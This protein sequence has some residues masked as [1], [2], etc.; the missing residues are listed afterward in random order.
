[1]P[2]RRVAA[3]GRAGECSLRPA[4]SHGKT[5]DLRRTR[6]G[7]R[8]VLRA[9]DRHAPAFRGELEERVCFAEQH[10]TGV[11]IDAKDTAPVLGRQR[12]DR[13]T[14]RKDAGVEHEHVNATEGRDGLRERGLE[15]CLVGEVANNSEVIA[16]LERAGDRRV[17]VEPHHGGSALQQRGY[18]GIRQSATPGGIDEES[19]AAIT[20]GLLLVLSLASCLVSFALE[21]AGLVQ[22]NR[23]KSFA[24]LGTIISALVGI[25]ASLTIL[26][27]LLVS[28]PESVAEH[29]A[30]NG[31][32]GQFP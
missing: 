11:E 13:C 9:D 21:I 12:R 2:R 25:G 8:D 3:R 1:V 14:R 17:K 6:S 22:A 27:G 4:S 24:I 18:A 15:R 29:A 30:G 7:C 20:I 5:C 31:T 32:L 10:E 16:A 23:N 26:L 28:S 19:P